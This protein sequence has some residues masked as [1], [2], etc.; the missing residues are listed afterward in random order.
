MVVCRI[1]YTCRRVPVNLI[2]INYLQSRSFHQHSHPLKPGQTCHSCIFETKENSNLRIC[3]QYLE[4][5][6]KTTCQTSARWMR[7]LVRPKF[8]FY[9]KP[10][11][12]PLTYMNAL[13]QPRSTM[14]NARVYGVAPSHG[15]PISCS[16]LIGTMTLF[17]IKS[18]A[19]IL[20]RWIVP[21]GTVK[22]KFRKLISSLL[23]ARDL[24]LTGKT[25]QINTLLTSTCR[26]GSCI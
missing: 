1:R 18:L 26:P 9:R 20:E 8:E 13:P 5:H 23:G 16:D 15:A 22:P 10:L 21:R 12:T 6:S 14:E 11:L 3:T 24:S 2:R 17:P 25:L 7:Y 4:H 19:S